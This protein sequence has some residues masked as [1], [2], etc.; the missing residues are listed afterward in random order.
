LAYLATL[1]F[2]GPSRSLRTLHHCKLAFL[3]LGLAPDYTARG[4]TVHQL[5]CACL[6]PALVNASNDNFKTFVT[7]PNLKTIVN[8]DSTRG[9]HRLATRMNFATVHRG[10]GKRPGLEEA[11]SPQPLVESGIFYRHGGKTSSTR[12]GMLFSN[13]FHHPI[14]HRKAAQYGAFNPRGGTPVTTGTDSLRLIEQGV[15]T[16]WINR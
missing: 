10:G 9:L 1:L 15:F 5:R 4:L 8:L 16:D 14:G 13:V 7:S 3:R 6:T 11:C 2:I 12:S